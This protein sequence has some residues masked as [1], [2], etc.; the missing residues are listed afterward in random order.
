MWQPTSWQ[1]GSR[2]LRRYCLPS[3]RFGLLFSVPLFCSFLL[4][5]RFFRSSLP[6]V[7]SLPLTYPFLFR[8]PFEVFRSL[9]RSTDFFD[10]VRLLSSVL[11]IPSVKCSVLLPCPRSVNTLRS[12]FQL[13]FPLHSPLFQTNPYRLGR[14]AFP[15]QTYC[16]I[17]FCNGVLASIR[18]VVF[19][20]CFAFL[21]CVLITL[22][23]T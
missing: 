8:S 5:L 2:R 14:W 11:C 23:K 1:N 15:K 20:F 10:T 16:T 19:D 17:V 21:F 7:V 3:F 13:L 12:C 4:L 22:I 18:N 6:F 9:L